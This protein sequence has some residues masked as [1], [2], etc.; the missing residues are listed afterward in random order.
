MSFLDYLPVDCGWIWNKFH[1]LLAKKPVRVDEFPCK[2]NRYSQ[3]I[4]DELDYPQ[5]DPTEYID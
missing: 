5:A 1:L 2:E 3:T 4:A